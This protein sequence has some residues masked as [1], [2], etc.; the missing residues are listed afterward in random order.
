[1]IYAEGIKGKA[2]I[3]VDIKEKK[4]TF[5]NRL[6]KKGPELKFEMY[7]KF[8]SGYLNKGHINIYDMANAKCIQKII[9]NDNFE[10]NHYSWDIERFKY[11]GHEV[12]M[13]DVNFDGY[14]DLRLLDNAGA[15]GNDW[16]AT[17]IY[18][19]SS[20]KFKYHHELSQLSGITID[21]KMKQIIT[22]NRGGYCDEYREYYKLVRNKLILLKVVTDRC[23]RA[24]R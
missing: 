4:I 2:K 20:G 18:N 22:Y 13:V 5:T 12:Q 9:I 8:Q 6:S 15:T 7:G 11:N 19:P 10:G 21:Q 16:Y 3:P 14:L 23:Y 1:M 24:I 17:Y